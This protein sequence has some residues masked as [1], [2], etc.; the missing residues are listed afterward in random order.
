MITVY[1]SSVPWLIFH[2]HTSKSGQT[3][4]RIWYKPIKKKAVSVQRGFNPQCLNLIFLNSGL[5]HA[6][7]RVASGC[8]TH[9]SSYPGYL[10]CEIEFA[11][12]RF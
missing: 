2:A 1:F 3:S 7:E 8:E 12:R 11:A 10:T 4:H 9:T 5:P 6:A